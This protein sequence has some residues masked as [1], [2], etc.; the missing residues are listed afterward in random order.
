[1]EQSPSWE[2]NQF[3]AKRF[4][5]AEGHYRIYQCPPPA[6]ILSQIIPS[7]YPT[8]WKSILILSSYLRLALPVGLFPSSFHTKTV[9]TAPPHTCYI[10]HQLHSSFGEEYRSLC[11]LHS[12]LH[13]P[14]TSSLLGSYILNTLFSNTL[15]L[16]SLLS[17]SD[18]VSH[19][20]KKQTKL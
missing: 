17:M 7:P 16:R 12:F 4:M 1:M 10:P 15:S 6:L 13:T 8:S 20:Y 19:P 5:E 9:Y 3:S 11:S 14:F 18:R 2:A